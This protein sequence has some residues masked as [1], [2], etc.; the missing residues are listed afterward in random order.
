[1]IINTILA[2]VRLRN[3]ICSQFKAGPRSKKRAEATMIQKKAGKFVCTS[4][5][6]FM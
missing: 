1:M 4:S 2:F 5:F 3:S 6:M